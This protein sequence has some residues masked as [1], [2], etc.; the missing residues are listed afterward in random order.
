MDALYRGD[1]NSQIRQQIILGVGGRLLKALNINPSVYHINEGRPGFLIWE[2]V[3][4][5]I[6]KEGKV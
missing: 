5:I 3:K 1:T 6:E 4:N 2:L